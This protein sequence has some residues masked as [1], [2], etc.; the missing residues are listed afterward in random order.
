MRLVLFVIFLNF[1][2]AHQAHAQLFEI[3]R[4]IFS[5]FVT[6]DGNY[7]PLGPE[8]DG[9]ISRA[10]L[11]R[12]LLYFS[13]T[14]VGGKPALE[15]LQRNRRL[16]VQ[17]AILNSSSEIIHGL[18]ITQHRW[19]EN[20]NAWLAQFNELGYFTFRTFLNT[21]NI[22]P[23]YVELQIRDVK[24]NVIRPVGHSGTTYKARVEIAP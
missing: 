15:Y 11:S 2:L 6:E 23:D 20:K 7:K 9:R 22:S 24:N 8:T 16:E 1:L 3:A 13:F 19:S 10:T 21:Q 14:V 12:G 17:A 18:G 4:P 5:Q